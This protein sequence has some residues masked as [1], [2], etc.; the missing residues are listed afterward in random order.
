MS[1][2]TINST[3]DKEAPPDPAT[4][5]LRS[6]NVPS[7]HHRRPRNSNSFQSSLGF[8]KL[9]V[10][11]LPAMAC[12]S[13][14]ISFYTK[15]DATMGGMA[16]IVFAVALLYAGGRGYAGVRGMDDERIARFRATVLSRLLTILYFAYIVVSQTSINMYSCRD[17]GMG[18]YLVS[19]FRIEC[20]TRE[21]FQNMLVGLLA[22]L[23]WPIGIPA[24]FL[25]LMFY[26]DLPRMAKEKVRDAWLLQVVEHAW[27]AGV[28]QPQC[29]LQ[30]L[31]CETMTDS[32]L[33]VLHAAFVPRDKKLLERAEERTNFEKIS[34][35]ITAVRKK[36]RAVLRARFFSDG[37]GDDD[38]TIEETSE[39]RRERLLN[40][41]L[42]WART[43]GF[44]AIPPLL[45]GPPLSAD[46]VQAP[47][48]HNAAEAGG[49]GESGSPRGKRSSSSLGRKQRHERQGSGR[50]GVACSEGMSSPAGVE[51]VILS[52]QPRDPR[53]GVVEGWG[54]GSGQG[55]GGLSA[56]APDRHTGRISGT[57]TTHLLPVLP[58]HPGS[59]REKRRSGSSGTSG[60]VAAAVVDG[61]ESAVEPGSPQP[62]A[63]SARLSRLGSLQESPSGVPKA[64]QLSASFN[65]PP[66]IHATLRGSSRAGQALRLSQ[67]GQS[68]GSPLARSLSKG[69]QL[70]FRTPAPLGDAVGAVPESGGGA[71]AAAGRKHTGGVVWDASQLAHHDSGVISSEHVAA[72]DAPA[73]P[74]PP[75]VPMPPVLAARLEKERKALQEAGF[76]VVNY[77]VPYFYW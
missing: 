36:S 58:D 3:V 57:D 50:V 12:V 48:G 33:E 14:N 47:G 28:A 4:N 27:Q 70:S 16:L 44:L 22:L 8:L 65:K 51:G 17:V 7:P 69:P 68:Q 38:E 19:D 39:A 67:S 43:C 24:A 77:Q 62:P 1:P 5:A 76:L 32:H 41:L 54:G 31:T 29:E 15:Y 37:D 59:H 18:V 56:A 53:G 61:T 35:K 60:R 40:E 66:L 6:A 63:T 75:P 25:L 45:W 52:P 20:Y 42:K 74:L 30:Y 73:E 34:R 9:D 55:E 13:P 10:F 71:S 49:G 46:S 26:H 11:S 2:V 64:P 23:A 21:H 72:D